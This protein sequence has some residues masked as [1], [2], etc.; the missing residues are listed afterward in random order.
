METEAVA[1]ETPEPAPLDPAALGRRDPAAVEVFYRT[2]FEPV[3]AF[4]F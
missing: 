2:L 4:V 3:Y 1:P